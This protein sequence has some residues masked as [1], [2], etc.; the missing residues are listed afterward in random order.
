MK[1]DNNDEKELGLLQCPSSRR[2]IPISDANNEVKEENEIGF[3]ECQSN[4]K[5]IPIIANENFYIGR[6]K[7]SCRIM[8]SCKKVSRIHARIESSSREV[9][10]R[11]YSKSSN[12]LINNEVIRPSPLDE[13]YL[14]KNQDRI[15]IGPEVFV[16][17]VKNYLKYEENVNPEGLGNSDNSAVLDSESKSQ[18]RGQRS[19]SIISGSTTEIKAKLINKGI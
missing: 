14:I 16:Y 8:V 5:R 3:L 15:Q 1:E 7:S 19:D 13:T 10:I 2:I 17:L 12:M 9:F 18:T 6:D 11:L 4:K